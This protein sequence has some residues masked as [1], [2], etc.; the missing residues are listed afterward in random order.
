MPKVTEQHRQARRAQIAQAAIRQF[1][2][3]GVHAATMAGI[4]EES[5]LS[6]GAIYT[7]FSSKEEIIAY[8]ARSTVDS[9][10]NRLEDALTGT[11]TIDPSQLLARIAQEFEQAGIEP[12]LV[13]QVW[14]EAVTT[15]AVRETVVGVFR[16]VVAAWADYFEA[17]LAGAGQ[18]SPESSRA[19]AATA[20]VMFALVTAQILQ[21]ALVADFDPRAFADDVAQLL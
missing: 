3:H 11:S 1:A 14:G 16:R 6:A 19:A 7:Y 21:S 4:I 2:R 8:A 10:L 13:V 12:S 9:M 17:R 15:P 5:G 18:P 20:R